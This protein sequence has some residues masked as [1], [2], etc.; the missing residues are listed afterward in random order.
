M[1]TTFWKN[2]ITVIITFSF[3]ALCVIVFWPRR[4]KGF[5]DASM[6]PLKEDSDALIAPRAS[7]Q[8]VSNNKRN[9]Q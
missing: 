9:E 3:I 1:D 7:K 5:E 4:V 8:D 6:L 2:L